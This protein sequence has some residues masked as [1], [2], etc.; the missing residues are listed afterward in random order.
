MGE[1]LPTKDL[2]RRWYERYLAALGSRAVVDTVNDGASTWIH[3][4]IAGASE[5]RPLP[6]VRWTRVQV[7][8]RDEVREGLELHDGRQSMELLYADD[9]A[10]VERTI[11]DLF[12]GRL[13]ELRRVLAGAADPWQ[14]SVDFVLGLGDERHGPGR[15]HYP[16]PVPGGVVT[17]W[18]HGL[19]GSR[20]ALFDGRVPADARFVVVDGLEGAVVGAGRTEDEARD[21]YAAAVA[22]RLP[23]QRRQVRTI[24]DDYDDEG[25]LIKRGELP[26]ELA[27]PPS[28][29]E[30]SGEMAVSPEE[31]PSWR[32]DADDEEP[33]DR[34]GV[35]PI[36]GRISFGP[37]TFRG[38][39]SDAPPVPRRPE[40]V[41]YVLLPLE[42]SLDT[43]LPRGRW[44]RVLGALGVTRHVVRIEEP[45]G[46]TL[47]GADLL[48][49]VDLKGLNA[50]LD[51]V[52]AK[53][54][55]A[56]GDP[57]HEPYVR[58]R[59]RQYRWAPASASRPEG[60]RWARSGRGPRFDAASLDGDDLQAMVRRQRRVLRPKTL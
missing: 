14:A 33:P 59:A 27:G 21:A 30:A 23:E 31:A 42:P 40:C 45:E 55:D 4:R 32:P 11:H 35:D 46:F 29:S 9:G 6:R 43:P 10:M 28:P 49:L 2:A 24:T 57:A 53:D 58:F 18:N 51:A 56:P 44:H 39:R 13:I 1:V 38:P 34:P 16:V 48:G 22:E 54:P 12:P 52:D 7:L 20:R 60:L 25:N 47:V 41:P 50:V 8:G 37:I 15:I 19:G 5:V 17:V 36:T 26:P 3:R